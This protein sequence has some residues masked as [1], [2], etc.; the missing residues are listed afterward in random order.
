MTG[1]LAA[2]T[3]VA[4][5][6]LGDGSGARM[7]IAIRDGRIAAVDTADRIGD[8]V[9]TD[10]LVFDAAGRAVWPGFVDSHTHFHRASIMEEHYLNFA[11]LEPQSI[12]D[13]LDLV[14]KRA[15]DTPEGEWIQGDSLEFRR[16]REQRLPTRE[17]LDAAAP[18]RF[19]V[20]RTV[21]R[22]A[23]SANSAALALAGIDA[24]T[25]APPGGRIERGPDGQP[26]GV[27]HEHG[28]L[29]LDM[30]RADTVVPKPDA[31]Q[32]RRALQAGMARLAAH[33]ITGIHD[34]V[35]E[36]VEIGDYIDLDTSVGLGVRIRMYVRGRES[37][38]PL[39]YLAS[40][41]LR[42]GF[43]SER[44]RIAGVKLSI[45]GDLANRNSAVYD[46]YPGEP[47]N[48]GL[49]RLTPDELTDA[50]V[51]SHRAQLPVAIHAIGPRA[52]DMALDAIE[53]ARSTHPE[54]RLRHRIEHAF[55]D[56]R[57]A[58]LKR[59]AELG[60]VWSTQPSMLYSSGDAWLA[61]SSAEFLDGVLPLRTAL[62]LGVDVQINSDHPCSP[63]DPFVGL[64]ACAQ[65]VTRDGVRLAADEA[66][67]IAEALRLMTDA[68]AATVGEQG[69]SG[70]VAVGKWADLIVVS[71]DPDADAGVPGLGVRVD[72]TFVGGDLVWDRAG[73][74]GAAA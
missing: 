62:D 3:V 21:G 52:V 63:L 48:R 20:L 14:R 12:E 64:R 22:H 47:D 29:R 18:G 28:K 50:V 7:S 16:L 25:A 31:A 73:G 23:L 70:A 51:R 37:Q 40:L 39:E 13:V 1:G 10:T 4:N 72:A 55:F 17:E 34:I 35:R 59:F 30:T 53:Q 43:G 2:D 67:T 57:G 69:H 15:A 6:R 71:P 54:Y 42:P 60:V 24:G 58:R 9:G 36:P 41:G 68:P 74:A 27:L 32:R 56:Q 61:A 8:L 26:N 11:M 66:I 33:G 44:L 46:A 19:V 49:L 5:C 65:R 45:D 38:T